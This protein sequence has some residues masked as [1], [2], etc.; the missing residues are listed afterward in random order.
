MLGCVLEVG[1]TFLHL[2]VLAAG[3]VVGAMLQ[4]FGPFLEGLKTPLYEHF[5]WVAGPL[6]QSNTIG[7]LASSRTTGNV[8]GA[9]GCRSQTVPELRKSPAPLTKFPICE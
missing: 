8:I 3:D 9:D 6:T 5:L 2:T 7:L 1:S 4:H